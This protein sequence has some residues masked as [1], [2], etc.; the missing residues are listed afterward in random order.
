MSDKSERLGA[1]ERA[2]KVCRPIYSEFHRGQ[3]ANLC[4]CECEPIRDAIR[5]AEAALREEMERDLERK[6]PCPHPARMWIKPQE[7]EAFCQVCKEA[8]EVHD[9]MTKR[10]D[11]EHP[12]AC[13]EMQGGGSLK[14]Q[15]SACRTQAQAVKE[16]EAALREEMQLLRGFGEHRQHC[17]RCGR[18]G[19]EN[20][21]AEDSVWKEI[22]GEYQDNVLC[23]ACF[24]TLAGEKGLEYTVHDLCFSGEH[25]HSTDNLKVH[26]AE[27]ARQEALEECK[28][29]ALADDLRVRDPDDPSEFMGPETVTQEA[30]AIRIQ[31]LM[32]K[33][34]HNAND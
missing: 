11:C 1:V 20:F 9:A 32:N 24:D 30:I 31:R 7:G 26:A 3:N 2:I 23:F 22:A 19:G 5:E 33:R 12:V 29:I 17:K 14:T 16:A 25:G 13:T 15:C 8:W 18:A 21:H 4:C 34:T 10:M 27:K 6:G 28:A